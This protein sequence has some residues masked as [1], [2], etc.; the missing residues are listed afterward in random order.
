MFLFS[1]FG[2]KS[3]QFTKNKEIVIK[4]KTDIDK[5]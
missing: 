3:I 2:G 5:A 1:V 4:N